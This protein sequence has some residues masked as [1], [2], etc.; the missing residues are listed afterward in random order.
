M[1]TATEPAAEADVLG[2]FPYPSY[3]PHQRETILRIVEAFEEGKRFVIIE[4][5]TGGG[6]SGIAWTIANHIGESYVVT[7]QKVL[8]DSADLF[9]SY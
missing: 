1:L 3:R 2:H 8:Q 4:V 5:P 6:K 9:R 7:A